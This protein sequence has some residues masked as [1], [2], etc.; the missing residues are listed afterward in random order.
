MIGPFAEMASA[1]PVAGAHA[2]WTW[3]LARAGVRGERQWSWFMN[4]FVLAGHL[5]KLLTG[6]YHAVRGCTSTYITLADVPAVSGEAPNWAVME[7]LD[8]KLWWNPVFQIIIVSVVAIILMTRLSRRPSFWV[9]VGVFNIAVVIMFMGMYAAGAARAPQRRK[10]GFPTRNEWTKNFAYM[11]FMG[12]PTK[13]IPFDAAAHMSEETRNPAKN[14]PRSLYVSAAIHFTLVY[15]T[16]ACFI[17]ALGVPLG[18][19]IFTGSESSCV[20]A[21]IGILG[22]PIKTVAGLAIIALALSASQFLA[23]L[24]ICSR[25]IFA[26]ARDHGLPFSKYLKMTDRHREPWVANIVLVFIAYLSL[27]CWLYE[28]KHYYQL[29]QAVST[30]IPLVCYFIPMTLYLFSHLDLQYEGRS[31]FTLRK[32]GKPS[33]AISAFWML[34]AIVQGF[35]PLCIWTTMYHK[36]IDVVSNKTPSYFPWAFI[37]MIVVMA[38]SWFLYGRRHFV[39]PVRAMTKWTAGVEISPEEERPNSRSNVLKAYL[40]GPDKDKDSGSKK[41]SGS[42]TPIKKSKRSS[43]G[44]DRAPATPVQQLAYSQASSN[45]EPAQAESQLL[46]DGQEGKRLSW[47]QRRDSRQPVKRR[48]DAVE[49]VEMSRAGTSGAQQE[50]AIFPKSFA[51]EESGIFPSATQTQTQMSIAQQ[52]SGIF[53]ATAADTQTQTQFSIAQQ[54]SGIF[55]TNTTRFSVAQQESQLM[56]S[57]VQTRYDPEATYLSMAQEES[58]ILPDELSYPPPP[59]HRPY[60]APPRRPRT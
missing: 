7:P 53:P 25:F 45:S 46:P 6:L 41:D 18:E 55:P 15:A 35:F 37:G 10:L 34:L 59:T 3:R 5:G 44:S 9:V 56:P 28:S 57:Q 17:F 31:Q 52:E 47:Y 50:S 54:E 40:S 58:Q 24:V 14:V 4:G 11:I 29:S 60:P 19:G 48:L 32:W 23:T 16:V 27:T 1:F 8:P 22:L 39:G 30:Y 12:M 21:L 26:V 42:G 20:V 38:V 2:S 51:Q 33:A 36:G 49:E 13:F 43:Y